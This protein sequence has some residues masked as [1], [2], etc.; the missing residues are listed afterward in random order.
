MA[1]S[2]V[3]QYLVGAS[4][5]SKFPGIQGAQWSC[6][7]YYSKNDSDEYMESLRA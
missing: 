4:N 6:N 2:K 5:K 7:M 1:T 3:T